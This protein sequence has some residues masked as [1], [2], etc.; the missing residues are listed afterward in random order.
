MLASRRRITS[1]A[2]ALPNS[3]T[4]GGAGTG[5]VGGVSLPDEEALLAEDALDAEDALE[6]DELADEPLDDQPLLLEL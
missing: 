3:R 6:E 2:A 1:A 5:V 4:I